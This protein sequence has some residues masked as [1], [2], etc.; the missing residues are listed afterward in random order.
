MV[1]RRQKPVYDP[2]L[3][4]AVNKARISLAE[5]GWSY[6]AAAKRLGRHYVHVSLVLRGHRESRRLLEA[7]AA[8]PDR[9]EVER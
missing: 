3:P 4:E 7:I 6:R 8:L 2:S 5:K 9:K 1:T